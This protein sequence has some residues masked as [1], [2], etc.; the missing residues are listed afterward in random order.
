[1]TNH[2]QSRDVLLIPDREYKGL[3][4]FDTKDQEAKFPK[5]EQ[6]HS[7]EGSRN[8]VVVL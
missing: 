1:V 8:V 7:P 4:K 3:I 2:N 5:M 6:L